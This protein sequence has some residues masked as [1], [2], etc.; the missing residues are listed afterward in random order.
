[1]NWKQI[2]VCISFLATMAGAIRW[3]YEEK[4]TI[5]KDKYE[6]EISSMSNIFSDTKGVLQLRNILVNDIDNMIETKGKY[7]AKSNTYALKEIND[8]K[9]YQSREDNLYALFDNCNQKGLWKRVLNSKPKTKPTK[10]QEQWSLYLKKKI[11][12]KIKPTINYWVYDNNAEGATCFIEFK[13]DNRTL[14]IAMKNTLDFFTNPLFF[15]AKYQEVLIGLKED[16]DKYNSKEVFEEFKH[17]FLNFARG[18]SSKKKLILENRNLLFMDFFFLDNHIVLLGV[19]N[20]EDINFAI[21]SNHYTNPTPDKTVEN[22]MTYWLS[23]YRIILN[24]N[25][26][27]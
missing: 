21:L 11:L 10:A 23:Q 8:F 22:K 17:F 19:L 12:S 7:F 5:Q 15:D 4:I 2:A 26:T 9:Y 25:D 3:I 24:Q 14:K 6:Q 1:M 13:V 20:R 16:L 27:D 18:L